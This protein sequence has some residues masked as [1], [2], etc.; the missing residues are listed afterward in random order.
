MKSWLGSGLVQN[1]APL[2]TEIFCEDGSDG[3]RRLNLNR[4]SEADLRNAK[5]EGYA[6]LAGEVSDAREPSEEVV[7]GVVLHHQHYNAGDRGGR[8]PRHEESQHQY[9]HESRAA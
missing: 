6:L 3:S 2:P 1:D 4:T 7:E 9:Q 5:S 8:S